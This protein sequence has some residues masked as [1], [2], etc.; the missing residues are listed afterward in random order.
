MVDGNGHACCVKTR[1]FFFDEI[2]F[3]HKGDFDVLALFQG[4]D[5]ALDFRERGGIRAHCVNSDSHTLFLFD[6]QDFNAAVISAMRAD[7]MGYNGLLAMAALG[8]GRGL[9]FPGCPAFVPPRFG[10]SSFWNGHVSLLLQFKQ[11]LPPGVDTRGA[12]RTFFLIQVYTAHRAQTGARLATYRGHRH[13]RAQLFRY[14]VRKVDAGVELREDQDIFV[15]RFFVQRAMTLERSDGLYISFE[16]F[17][18]S[19]EATGAL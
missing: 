16:V 9:Q 5:N 17:A 3:S 6:P 13:G 11:R 8:H 14:Q 1:E 10:M 12:A 7:A 15:A 19:F 2:L 4:R 18:E